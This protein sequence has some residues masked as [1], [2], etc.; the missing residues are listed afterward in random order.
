MVLDVTAIKNYHEIRSF[1][2]IAMGLDVEKI[3]FFLPE[4]SDVCTSSFLSK[5]VLW[6]YII[7][8]LI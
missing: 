3:V 6:E 1:Q 8:L 4:G 7:L 5:L 2:T